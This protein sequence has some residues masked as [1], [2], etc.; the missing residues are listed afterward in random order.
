[1]EISAHFS[2]SDWPDG[3]AHAPGL[4]EYFADT[5]RNFAAAFI[6]SLMKT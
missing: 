6:R 1:L 3:E 5:S 4:R 2:A